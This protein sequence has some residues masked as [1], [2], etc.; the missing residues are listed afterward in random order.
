MTFLSIFTPTYRR[1]SFLKRCVESVCMQ[2]LWSADPALSEIQHVIWED[3]VGVGVA[4]MYRELA[5]QAKRLT[6]E[7]VY[8]LQDDDILAV[9]SVAERLKH[10]AYENSSPAVIICRNTKRGNTYPI[11]WQQAPVLGFID[12][13]NFVV[14]RDV[15]MQHVGDFGKEYSGDYPFIKRLWDAGYTFGWLDMLLAQAQA[16]GLGRPEHELEYTGVQ[17]AVTQPKERALSPRGQVKHGR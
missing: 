17:M 13:G 1:P 8:I 2:T 12:L 15:Y 5:N 16:L 4:G 11:T 3:R 10:F 14:R 9:D 7:Y 6:G